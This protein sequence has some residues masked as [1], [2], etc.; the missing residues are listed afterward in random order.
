MQRD[1]MGIIPYIRNNTASNVCVC[2]SCQ[3]ECQ[4]KK[5]KCCVIQDMTV[6]VTLKKLSRA[7]NVS[8]ALLGV[9][10]LTT[11]YYGHH[12]SFI[13]FSLK[14]QCWYWAINA[15]GQNLNLCYAKSITLNTVQRQATT[16]KIL[17]KVSTVYLHL[18]GIWWSSCTII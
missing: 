15:K 14:T 10:L 16:T 13:F 2:K 4:M 6:S 17:A 9:A 11:V 3:D 5:L 1:N 12:V 8:A 18:F 7:T